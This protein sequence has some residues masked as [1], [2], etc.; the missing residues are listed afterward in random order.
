MVSQRS[1]QH[2]K[3]N[4]EVNTTKETDR[5]ETMEE[6]KTVL[7]IKEQNKQ[8]RQ[9]AEGI[10]EAGEEPGRASKKDGCYPLIFSVL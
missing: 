10:T 9:P 6:D 3:H 2:A 7:S 1:Y 8:T 5:L 4:N